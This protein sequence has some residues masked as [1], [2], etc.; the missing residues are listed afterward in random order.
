MASGEWFDGFQA[1]S[2]G[3]PIRDDDRFAQR[4]S[5]GL[6]VG[7]KRS[8]AESLRRSQLAQKRNKQQSHVVVLGL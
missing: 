1:D 6:R 2:G 5:V 3:Q 8:G 7:R 4:K